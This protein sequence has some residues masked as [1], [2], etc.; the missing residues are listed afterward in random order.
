MQGKHQNIY[1]IYIRCKERYFFWVHFCRGVHAT[2]SHV[3]LS[4]QWSLVTAHICNHLRHTICYS[5]FL[6]SIYEP[7]CLLSPTYLIHI[8][9]QELTLLLSL[10]DWFLLYCEIC[11]DFFIEIIAMTVWAEPRIW[12][13]SILCTVIKFLIYR[14]NIC[15]S[16]IHNN[17]ISCSFLHVLVACCHVQGDDTPWRWQSSAKTCRSKEE[18]VLLCTLDVYMLVL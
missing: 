14:T 13:L 7:A 8:T 6:F 1:W 2:F 11:F 16:N 12:T 5:N 3:L 17:I 10:S 9:F 4:Y 18:I 15:T